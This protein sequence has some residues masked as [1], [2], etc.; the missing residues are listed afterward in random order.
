M[1][2]KIK[3]YIKK[4]VKRKD[5]EIYPDEIFLDSKNLPDFNVHQMEGRIE[6][7]ISK[8]IFKFISFFIIFVATVFVY[9]LWNLQIKEGEIYKKRTGRL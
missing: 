7:P 6:K 9:K 8:E 2:H 1:F 4:R 3:R 5:K